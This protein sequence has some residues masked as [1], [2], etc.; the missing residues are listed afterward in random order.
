MTRYRTTNCWCDGELREPP[1]LRSTLPSS[2]TQRVTSPLPQIY[3]RFKRNVLHHPSLKFSAVSSASLNGKPERDLR[4]KNSPSSTNSSANFAP[5]TAPCP[6]RASLHTSAYQPST[7]R[8]QNPISCV[9]CLSW[10]PL[11]FINTAPFHIAPDRAHIVTPAFS[12]LLTWLPVLRGTR[13]NNWSIAAARGY[14]SSI[15]CQRT[16]KIA[17]SSTETPN[18]YNHPLATHGNQP[19]TLYSLIG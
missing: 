6:S 11:P 10:S 7:I 17:P 1:S 2:Q 8:S 13:L 19:Q 18:S 9:L 3:L 14:G 15:V 5:A 16:V 12:Q 4:P